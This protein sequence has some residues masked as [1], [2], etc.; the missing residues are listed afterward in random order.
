MASK[1]LTFELFGVDKTASKAIAG[2]G[3]AGDDMG[4]LVSRGAFV[5]GAALAT[6]AISAVAF[7]VESIKAFA[8]AEQ[9]QNRLAFAYEKFPALANGNVEAIKK[10]NT[11]LQK[12]TRFDDDA[13]AAAEGTLAQYDLTA[14]Q[15]ER[16]IPLLADY[17]AATGKDAGDAAEDLGKAILGQGRALK[18]IGIDFEDAGDPIANYTALIEGLTEKVGGFAEQDANTVSGR[19]DQIQN[20]FGEIQE[21][22]GGAFKP[23]LTVAA[24]I[25]ENTLLPKLDQMID[26]V[27]PQLE[28]ELSELAP[29]FEDAVDKALPALEKL[30]DAAP[31][32]LGV[33]FDSITGDLE[34]VEDGQRVFE[35]IDGFFSEY[36]P[37]WAAGTVPVEESW[38]GFFNWWDL[39]WDGVASTTENKSDEIKAYWSTTVYDMKQ[40]VFAADMATAGWQFAQGFADGI[41]SNSES[42]VLAAERMALRTADRVRTAMQIQSPS[43]LMR[44]MGAYIPQGL[45]L[46]IEDDLWRVDAA[47]NNMAGSAVPKIGGPNTFAALG[48]GNQYHFHG[49]LAD[50]AAV[51][52]AIDSADR[53][54]VKVGAVK[55]SAR[56]SRA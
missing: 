15:L 19:L 46:G 4:K 8:E 53:Y 32:G 13:L 12:K 14:E 28:D 39:A 38:D 33:I 24:D 31:D 20:Q 3:R 35:E 21:K 56:G 54:A 51:G 55:R 23:G 16:L 2:V 7:S 43:K 47:A 34:M 22:L 41:E 52:K 18:A 10:L 9:A 49:V 17:A 48:G 50:Q 37:K 42:A 27:G 29:R 11:E 40:A 1:S 6:V 30:L 26:K 5:A 36:L 25:I 45:A 44:K